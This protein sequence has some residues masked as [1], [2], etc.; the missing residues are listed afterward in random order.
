ME[1]EKQR[2]FD[3]IRSHPAWFAVVTVRRFAYVWTGF[4]S[5]D[6]RYLAEEPL[7]PP[8]VIFCTA[9]TVPMLVGLRRLWRENRE[10]AAFFSLL[11][12][13]FPL[14]FYLTHTEVYVRRQIDPL[15]LVLAVYALAGGESGS[16]DPV[17]KN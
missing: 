1:R 2:G 11:L 8:N 17:A 14:V 13:F 3:F 4:W 16:G 12:F 9:L 10:L 15:I 7:D 5:F 6:K